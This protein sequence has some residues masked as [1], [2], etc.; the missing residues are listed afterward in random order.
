MFKRERKECGRSV[1]HAQ[2]KCHW[3]N[4]TCAGEIVCRSAIRFKVFRCFIACVVKLK[5]ACVCLCDRY[6][7]WPVRKLVQVCLLSF[8]WRVTNTA[9]KLAIAPCLMQRWCL[10]LALCLFEVRMRATSVARYVHKFKQDEFCVK[11]RWS[12]CNLRAHGVRSVYWRYAGAI[13]QVSLLLVWHLLL[14]P[15][16]FLYPPSCEVRSYWKVRI[17]G[18]SVTRQL[19]MIGAGNFARVDAKYGRLGCRSGRCQKEGVAFI[20]F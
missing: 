4:R 19:C 20:Y 3:R 11:L 2:S 13:E 5:P 12:F 9:E 8:L 17:F 16:L 7:S 1:S 6:L 14:K 18:N 10:T 15:R